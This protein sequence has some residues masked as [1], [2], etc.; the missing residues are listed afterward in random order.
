MGL[1]KDLRP[2]ALKYGEVDA[3]MLRTCRS[4]DD[5]EGGEISFCGTVALLSKIQ[6]C[7]TAITDPSLKVDQN[8]RPSPIFVKRL[9]I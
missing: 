1:A 8:N 5:K 2:S 7:C 3:R 9:P 4:E 6:Y